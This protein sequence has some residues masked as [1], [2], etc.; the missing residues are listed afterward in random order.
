MNKKNIT[1]LMIKQ[2]I[3]CRYSLRILIIIPSKGYALLGTVY[4]NLI[5]GFKRRNAQKQLIK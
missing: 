4:C 1:I 2:T 5:T 3:I